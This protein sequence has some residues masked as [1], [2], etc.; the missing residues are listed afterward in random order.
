MALT[1][2]LSSPELN[3][4]LLKQVTNDLCLELGR[5][6]IEAAV[7][8]QPGATDDKAIDLP[9]WAQIT[10]AAIPSVALLINVLT[11]RVQRSKS[12]TIKVDGNSGQP[13]EISATNLDEEKLNQLFA[14][15]V[16]SNE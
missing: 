2:T 1:L 13:I 8:T 11:A 3:A 15:Y 10:V 6:D 4:D 14:Q 5:K 7:S 12:L 16:K 9:V